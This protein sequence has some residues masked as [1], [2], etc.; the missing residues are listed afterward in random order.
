[1]ATLS[2]PP[3]VATLKTRATTVLFNSDAI[4]L[5]AK[6]ALGLIESGL[7]EYRV[8]VDAATRQTYRRLRGVDQFDRVV[9]NVRRLVELARER[10]GSAP[11][12]SL[13]FTA[14]RVNLHELP[15]FVGL[16]AEL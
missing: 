11:R 12:V 9:A 16:A 7:D 1:M 3:V 14:A 15:A 8:S 10:S 6:R 2:R 13:W 5:T 4:S